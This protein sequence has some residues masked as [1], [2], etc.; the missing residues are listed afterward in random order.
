MI[1]Q[2][3]LQDK[4]L[5]SNVHQVP[6]DTDVQARDGLR[7][8]KFPRFAVDLTEWIVSQKA[9]GKPV[10][11]MALK[12][13]Q[14]CDYARNYLDFLAEEARIAA[15]Q[16]D[17]P[18]PTPA[19]VVAAAPAAVAAPAPTPAPAPV[20]AATVPAPVVAAAPAP[21]APAP[22]SAAPDA[23]APKKRGRKP[24][25]TAGTTQ[26]SPAAAAAPTATPTASAPVDAPAPSAPAAP[27]ESEP[28]AVEDVPVGLSIY[29][30][31][32]SADA[33][34]ERDTQAGAE[35]RRA[36]ITA[37]MASYRSIVA[38]H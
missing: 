4:N 27:T 1:E 8:I 9:E 29:S 21:A 37:A 20:P 31:L 24:A 3:L 7:V 13:S 33:L 12:P 22:A 30:L 17:A 38:I 34:S 11:V 23:S 16:D 6:R 5:K 32:H 26:A 10:D 35:K 28:L 25:A 14:V 36:T 19:P 2:A 18:A 15:S